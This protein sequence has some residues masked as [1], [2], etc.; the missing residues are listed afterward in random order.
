MKKKIKKGSCLK[1]RHG[2]VPPATVPESFFPV[3]EERKHDGAERSRVRPSLS[4]LN[5]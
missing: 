3:G 4:K 5:L 2:G 1:F